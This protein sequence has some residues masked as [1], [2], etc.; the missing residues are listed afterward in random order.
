MLL[1]KK[2]FSEEEEHK[3]V[4]AIAESEKKTTG[5]IR[6]YVEKVCDVP[7]PLG[8]VRDLF[9]SNEMQ[10]TENRTGVLIYLAYKSHHFAIWGDEGISRCLPHDFWDCTTKEAIEFFRQGKYLD[11]VL[12]AIK[13]IGDK[14]IHNFPENEDNTKNQ[15]P[16]DI[17]YG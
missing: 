17:I 1:N 12:G 2:L 14:L 9:F 11:G 10:Y 5:E 3:I 8:R 7:D 16:D 15:L 13:S 6:L 4:A